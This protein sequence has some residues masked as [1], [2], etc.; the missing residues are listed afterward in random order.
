MGGWSK[1]AKKGLKIAIFG[2][3]SRKITKKF[4]PSGKNAKVGGVNKRELGHFFRKICKVTPPTNRSARVYITHVAH[5][6]L[7]IET[8]YNNLYVC[9]TACVDIGGR[10]LTYVFARFVVFS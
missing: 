2:T 3:F 1:K 4:C 7:G 5:H 10:V 9:I 8:F 6:G